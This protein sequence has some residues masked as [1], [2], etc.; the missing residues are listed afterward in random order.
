MVKIRKIDFIN[1]IIFLFI[2]ADLTK[3]I[4]YDRMCNSKRGFVMNLLEM[5]KQEIVNLGLT[6]KLEIAYYLYRRTGEIFEYDLSFI[7]KEKSEQEKYKS[8][9]PDDEHITDKNKVCFTW[10]KSYINLLNCFGIKAKY[11]DSK[12]HAYVEI[13]IDNHIIKADLMIMGADIMLTKVGLRPRN[14]K[15][16]QNKE[17]IKKVENSLLQKGIISLDMEKNINNSFKIL[18]TFKNY[19]KNKMGKN[20]KEEYVYGVFRKIE[21]LVDSVDNDLG[22]VSGTKFI[23]YLLDV[24]LWDN[25]KPIETFFYNQETGVYIKLYLV[26]RKDGNPYYYA[27]QK[28]NDEHYKFVSVPPIYV[29]CLLKSDLKQYTNKELIQLAQEDYYN[30]ILSLVDNQNRTRVK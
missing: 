27:Y 24:F 1:L 9:I 11:K 2:Y 12:R 22:E 19:L 16:L 29:E 6:D 23:S 21:E 18:S 28:M 8:Y 3:L 25:D 13:L 4:K 10:A 15:C 5:I 7:Y 14:F 30:S 17:L 26:K 20:Y